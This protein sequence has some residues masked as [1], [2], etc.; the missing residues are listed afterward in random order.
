M[1][2]PVVSENYRPRRLIEYC[3]VCKSVAGEPC[4]NGTKYPGLFRCPDDECDQLYER[5]QEALNCTVHL[6]KVAT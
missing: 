1:N 6:G 5:S 3:A 2:H 4:Q